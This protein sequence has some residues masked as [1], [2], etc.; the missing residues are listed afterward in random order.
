M[1][2]E[3]RLLLFWLLRAD[4]RLS[5]LRVLLPC[6][7]LVCVRLPDRL[8]AVFVL[9]LPEDFLPRVA[10]DDLLIKWV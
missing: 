8:P 4:D 5:V 7:L 3:E 2:V 10:V 1:P 6:A 9:L